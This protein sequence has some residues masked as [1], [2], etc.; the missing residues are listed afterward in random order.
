MAEVPPTAHG[1]IWYGATVLVIDNDLSVRGILRRM[2]EAEGFHVEEAPDGES[3]LR[4]IQARTEP[5]DLVLT[6]VHELGHS[7]GLDHSNLAG[8]IMAPSISPDQS[9]TGLDSTD[10]NSIRS[11]YASTGSTSTQETTT[12]TTSPTTLNDTDNSGDPPPRRF[13]VPR[14]WHPRWFERRGTQR[15]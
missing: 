9:F 10:V 7:L 14:A 5:F 1:P 6:A 3:A 2:L 13:R 4:L 12:T 8:S 15:A 11:L